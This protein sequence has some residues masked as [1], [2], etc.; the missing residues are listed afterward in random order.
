MIVE[1]HLQQFGLT[2]KQSIVYLAALKRGTS[3]PVKIAM[4]ARLNRSTTY[5]ILRELA[6][7][8]LVI[9]SQHK[10]KKTFTAVP[11]ERF[12]SLMEFRAK[13][14]TQMADRARKILPELRS[15]M[16][17]GVTMPKVQIYEGKKGIQNAYEDTLTSS[18]TIRAYAS[19]DDTENTLPDYFPD[20]YKRRAK[21][22][23]HIDAIFPHTEMAIALH[24]RDQ[25]EDRTSLLVPPDLYQFSPEI[26]IYDKKVAFF[27]W[28]DQFA[29]IIESEEMAQAQKRIFHLAWE[30]A[31]RWEKRCCPLHGKKTSGN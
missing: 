10:N 23:I 24:K 1:D 19:V 11:P 8:G 28:R 5:V 15:M 13:H 31:K 2:P 29:M 4:E 26:N 22:G 12:V 20:Y 16:N 18:E 7:Q 21:N 17:S 3:F 27:S 6:E 30:E 9:Q 14:Y 25:K